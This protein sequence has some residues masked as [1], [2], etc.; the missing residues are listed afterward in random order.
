LSLEPQPV[1]LGKTITSMHEAIFGEPNLLCH[2]YTW[3]IPG[4]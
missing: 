2:T 4:A 3:A 1:A